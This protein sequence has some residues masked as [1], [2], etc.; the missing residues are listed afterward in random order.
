MDKDVDMDGLHGFNKNCMCFP[1][2]AANAANTRTM[3]QSVVHC[4]QFPLF[5]SSSSYG[6]L[7]PSPGTLSGAES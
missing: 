7:G 4:D 6:V 1:A 2:L 5:L 3:A